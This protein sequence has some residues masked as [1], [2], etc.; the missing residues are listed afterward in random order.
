MCQVAKPQCYAV[1]L[2]M[3]CVGVMQKKVPQHQRMHDTQSLSNR[4][5]NKVL[6]LY[7]GNWDFNFHT[8]QSI[9]RITEAAIHRLNMIYHSRQALDFPQRHS[10]MKVLTTMEKVMVRGTGVVKLMVGKYVMTAV[11]LPVCNRAD[12]LKVEG[13]VR[14]LV[15]AVMGV[16]VRLKLPTVLPDESVMTS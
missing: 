2:D 4:A 13:S 12:A 10:Q 14:E 1:P 7:D 8:M 3:P 5:G 16:D 11:Y 15:L 9:V 6:S